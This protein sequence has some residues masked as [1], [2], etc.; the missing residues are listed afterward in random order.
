[1]VNM[2]KL[3][4]EDLNFFLQLITSAANAKTNEVKHLDMQ[5]TVEKLVEHTFADKQ[6]YKGN[7]I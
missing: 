3:E 4:I 6:T 5:L 7:F 1:M 2:K